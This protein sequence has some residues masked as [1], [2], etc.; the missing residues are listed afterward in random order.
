MCNLSEPLAF[1][2]TSEWFINE[3]AQNNHFAVCSNPGQIVSN[4]RRLVLV[5][6]FAICMTKWLPFG[7][8]IF[9]FK[10][11][12]TWLKPILHVQG[13]ILEK[14]EQKVCTC[15]GFSWDGPRKNFSIAWRHYFLL[16]TQ[17]MTLR[18]CPSE[19]FGIT[20]AWRAVLSKKHEG[21]TPRIT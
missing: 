2:V 20:G 8:G 3:N 4:R 10:G 13:R 12:L 17:N 5:M 16:V 21:Q 6:M 15:I 9:Y 1:W 11:S 18:F 19:D 7:H 14:K